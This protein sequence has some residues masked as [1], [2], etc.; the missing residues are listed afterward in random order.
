LSENYFKN[1]FLKFEFV[2]E[3][4]ENVENLKFL[5]LNYVNLEELKLKR[6]LLDLKINIYT[7][8]SRDF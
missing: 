4:D 8:L 7:Q 3:N 6:A 1:H 2:F 5:N